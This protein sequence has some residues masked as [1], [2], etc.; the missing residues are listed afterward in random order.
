[1]GGDHSRAC[2]FAP[3]TGSYQVA[4]RAAADVS[5][6]ALSIHP[7]VAGNHRHAMLDLEH[8]SHAQF[9]PVHEDPGL[10]VSRVR[11]CGNE[12]ND[13][14]QACKF[15]SWAHLRHSLKL[16]LLDKY[17]RKRHAIPEMAIELF[18]AAI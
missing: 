16:G 18:P 6:S 17:L 12:K 8:L 13:R 14:R 4:E 15:M 1:F 9:A 3:L 11:Q 10:C 5:E 7:I 2:R